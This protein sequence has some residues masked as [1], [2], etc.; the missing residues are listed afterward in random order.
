MLIK[1]KVKVLITTHS[2]YFVN[3]IN[4]LLMLSQLSARRRAA[5]GYSASEVLAPTDVGAYLFCPSDDGSQVER[6]DVTADTGIPTD[7]FTNVHSALYNEAIALE[8][9]P[10]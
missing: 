9:I 8:H 5:R 1:S 10:Q 2:D 6:L 7:P 3:Q 4:N